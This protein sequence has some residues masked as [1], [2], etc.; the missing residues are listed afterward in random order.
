[1]SVGLKGAR[2]YFPP[3]HFQGKSFQITLDSQS[4]LDVPHPYDVLW[5]PSPLNVF[6][7]IIQ[8]FSL[9]PDAHSLFS[10]HCYCVLL[11]TTGDVNSLGC[12]HTKQNY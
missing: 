11:Y 6:K 3:P 7:E 2:F 10:S 1:M 8:V 9:I 5:P 12:K 4:C